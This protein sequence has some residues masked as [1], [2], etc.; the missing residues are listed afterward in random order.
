M[1]FSDRGSY[2]VVYGDIERM[3]SM[4]VSACAQCAKADRAGK[5]KRDDSVEALEANNK[6]VDLRVV[7]EKLRELRSYIMSLRQ[8]QSYNEVLHKQMMEYLLVHIYHNA[9]QGRVGA[10]A[11]VCKADG[12]RL[13]S[14]SK[15]SKTC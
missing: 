13:I 9:P 12:M 11:G 4:L 2:P 8:L 3:D 6:W 15:C 14:D 7:D 1:Y 10:I 5:R